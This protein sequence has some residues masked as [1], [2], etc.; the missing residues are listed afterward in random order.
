MTIHFFHISRK[1]YIP[2]RNLRVQ[3]PRGVFQSYT[4]YFWALLQKAVKVCDYVKHSQNF[5]R[6]LKT[7][8]HRLAILMQIT[9]GQF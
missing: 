8:S 2:S 4:S 9:D 7:F 1:Q 3:I 5:R 6:E